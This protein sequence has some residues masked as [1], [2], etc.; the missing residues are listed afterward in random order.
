MGV[1]GNIDLIDRR[2]STA[3]RP[4]LYYDHDIVAN[5]NY[6]DIK[7]RLCA[8]HARHGFPLNYH[9][10]TFVKVDSGHT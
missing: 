10:R 7:L 1:C 5:P 6:P 3:L 4:K 8:G 9:Q 2:P